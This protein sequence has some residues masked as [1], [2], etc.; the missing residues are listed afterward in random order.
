MD[1]SLQLPDSAISV[2][3]AVPAAATAGR[4]AWVTA[5]LDH[6]RIA[7][8]AF[9]LGL[10]ILVIRV[11]A[12]ESKALLWL[13]VLAFGGFVIHHALPLRLR[14]PFFSLLSVAGIGVILGPASAA[15]LLFL[16]LAILAA[17]H[18]P[19]PFWPRVGVI[20]VLAAFFA[21]ARVELLPVPFSPAIWPVLG[22]MFMFRLMVYLYDVYHQAAPFGFS[23]GLAY[24]FMLPNVCFP[25]FPVV[26]YKGFCR[27]H[28]NDEATRIYQ[29]GI[30]WMFRGVI[31]LLLYRLVYQVFLVDP[32]T[33]TDAAGAARFAVA[34]YLLY[35]KVSGSF[36]FIVGLLHL[37]GF[38]LSETNHLYLLS[39]SFTDFWR[40][41]NIYWKDF[42]LKL[43]FNPLYFR[44]KKSMRA[45][46]ALVTATILAFAVTWLLHS[47]QLFWIRGDFPILWQ[48]MVFW[49]FLAVGVAVTAVYE[50]KN[51]R[52]RSLKKTLPSLQ[53]RLRRA[54]CTMVMFVVLCLLWTLWTSESFD[55]WL[56]L[57]SHAQRVTPGGLLILLGGLSLIGLAG[58]LL[59][60]TSREDTRS[61][62]RSAVPNSEFWPPVLRVG[63]LCLLLLWVGRNPLLFSFAPS[64][65][66]ALDNLK[67]PERLNQR[68]A[69]MLERG[70]YEDLTN[71][72]RFNPQL[73]ELYSQRPTDWNAGHAVQKTGGFPPYELIPS[74]QVEYKG[75]IQSTNRFGMRDREYE[76][77]K[78]AGTFRVA[79]LGDS[80]SKGSGVQDSETF[81]NVVE[82]R[83]N[84]EHVNG[85]ITQFEILN[86]S[87]GGYGPL[88][89]LATLEQKV[90][91]FGPDA[92][93]YEGIDDLTW[94]V[95]ELANAADREIE[96]PFERVSTIVKEAGVVK[97]TPRIV[98]E[99]RIK[100]RA[101]ELL[102]WVYARFAESCR[103]RGVAALA[104][105]LPRPESLPEE[106]ALLAKQMKLAQESGLE[107]FDIS[108]A[109]SGIED[110]ESLWLA[111]WDRHPNAEGHRRLA[112]RFYE[113][114]CQKVLPGSAEGSQ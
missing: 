104:T 77:I 80:H 87:V 24:F 66:E 48:D 5:C 83:L 99:Q 82:D 107:V 49:G 91:D 110:L 113:G 76:R 93:I 14:L 88:C 74:Q 97:G 36:H 42:I 108:E 64:V 4:P 102:R 27:S 15:W 101:E 20:I 81:E 106:R 38:N 40:R 60:H 67:H 35:L 79:L 112:Q 98:A 9:E 92:V 19:I 61:G 29:T 96:I 47:Y 103:T 68:D 111:K 114:I 16:G 69:K 11:F 13:M 25:L 85:R 39:S 105:F 51:T 44:F 2:P 21:A 22:S 50:T 3:P 57:L 41:I 72:A 100:P 10:L 23:R 59:G 70:Y 65:A 54:A 52:Q 84:R 28:Y 75:V 17:A 78:P 45:P 89:R 86:F 71:A 7:A 90:F 26:D 58:L 30:E 95:N 37:F 94:I 73:A 33:I 6:V 43:F 8:I 1:T 12:I 18:L 55:G 46:A 32:A 62:P 34:T 31:H 63:V 109:Y 56:L 53:T